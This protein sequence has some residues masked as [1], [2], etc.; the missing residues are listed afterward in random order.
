[1]R[2]QGPSNFIASLSSEFVAAAFQ[3]SKSSVAVLMR[4]DNPLSMAKCMRVLYLLESRET[5]V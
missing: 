2:P 5:L 1:M 3:Q 4:L